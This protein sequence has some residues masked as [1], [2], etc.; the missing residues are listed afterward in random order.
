MPIVKGKVICGDKGCQDEV[1]LDQWTCGRKNHVVPPELD[2]FK[3]ANQDYLR[4][5]ENVE[6]AN[7]MKFPPLYTPKVAHKE[8][9]AGKKPKPLPIFDQV[10]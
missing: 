4:E 1:P 6:G 10:S 9:V 7:K 2:V 3:Q 8:A 5:S